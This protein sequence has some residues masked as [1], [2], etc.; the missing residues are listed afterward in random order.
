MHNPFS[1]NSKDRV[2]SE[3]LQ[4]FRTLISDKTPS[5]WDSLLLSHSATDSAEPEHHWDEIP[6]MQWE[7][8]ETPITRQTEKPTDTRIN[9]SKEGREMSVP[10]FSDKET[11]E[12]LGCSNRAKSEYQTP[13]KSA[14]YDSIFE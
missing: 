6:D 3:K 13:V 11:G 4:Q 9:K 2:L 14:Y 1:S 5:F 8:F 10:L 7:Q 12:L